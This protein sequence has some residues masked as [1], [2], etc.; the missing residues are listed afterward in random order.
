M[1]AERLAKED[2]LRH[3]AERGGES[4][5]DE[6]VKDI[7]DEALAASMVEE[8]AR[9]GL[10]ERSD[11]RVWLTRAGERASEQLLRRHRESE[12]AL[13]RLLGGHAHLAAH[14]LEHLGLD[15]S[16]LLSSIRE[17][18]R[19]TELGKGAVAR[20]VAVLEPNPRLLARLYGVGVVPGRRV[21]VLTNAGGLVVVESSG[22]RLAAL[23]SKAAEKVLVAPE[24]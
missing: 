21:R 17:L 5:L 24:A 2:V 22:G 10:V 23:D 14:S 18:R 9:E 1:D 16:K 20:I 8:L 7:G 6:I 15:T 4:T 19:L 12:E 13:R 3:L 11:S